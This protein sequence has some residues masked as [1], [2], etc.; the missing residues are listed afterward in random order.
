MNI[1]ENVSNNPT[2]WSDGDPVRPH[3]STDFKTSK[4]REVFGLKDPSGSFLS[5]VCVAYTGDIPK[6]EEDLDT[7]ASETPSV[8][9][10][11]SVWS[12]KRGAGREIINRA[13]DMLRE[14]GRVARVI[15]LSPITDMARKFHLKNNATLLRVNET[16]VNFEYKL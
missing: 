16:T 5:F 9:V 15:T 1:I 3:L 10:P 12:L 14:T 13:L 4:G 6:S 11:Y 2:L 8:A 7:M